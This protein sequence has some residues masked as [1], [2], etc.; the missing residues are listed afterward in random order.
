MKLQQCTCNINK[1]ICN[2]GAEHVAHAEELRYIWRTTRDGYDNSD[3]SKFPAEDVTTQHRMLTLWTNF[4]KTLYVDIF[5]FGNGQKDFK[6]FRNPTPEPDDL[7]QNVT[8]PTITSGSED[9]FFYLDI[10]ENLEVKNHPKNDTYQNWVVLYD[11]L[12]Y[13]DFD[14][15]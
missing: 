5:F 11:A 7:L 1:Y 6:L 12:N 2:V 9:D 3:L 15:Y 4:V 14:T 8:W 13:E 10:G